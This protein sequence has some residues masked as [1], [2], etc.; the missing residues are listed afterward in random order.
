M[1]DLKL[2]LVLAG[3]LVLGACANM[4]AASGPALA[5]EEARLPTTW[6]APPLPHQG[7]KEAM[8]EW[9]ARMGDPQLP[10][11]IGLAQNSSPSLEAARVKLPTCATAWKMRIRS[12]SMC[13]PS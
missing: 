11:L 12:Q 7:Q 4:G 6:Y 3:T 10:A 8:A 9:W 13:P 1:T 5:G 2:G